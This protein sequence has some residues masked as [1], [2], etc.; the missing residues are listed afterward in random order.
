MK[1]RVH[2]TNV[3]AHVG[4]EDMTM[5][6]EANIYQSVNDTYSIVLSGSPRHTR[7]LWNSHD[8]HLNNTLRI[9]PR[10]VNVERF[11]FGV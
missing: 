9:F 5:E 11:T 7:C 8:I 6:P 4:R 2:P 10:D 1:A 3:Q